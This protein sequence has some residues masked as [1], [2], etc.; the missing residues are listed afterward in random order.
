MDAAEA[1][2]ADAFL[3]EAIVALMQELDELRNPASVK[4]RK[5]T[6]VTQAA[7]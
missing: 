1:V 6:T 7:D 2:S 5:A 4:A 3:A